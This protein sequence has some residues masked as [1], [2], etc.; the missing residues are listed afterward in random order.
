[1]K[2]IGLIGGMSWESTVTYYE[3]LNKEVAG[4]LG[5]FHSA[6]ILMYNV[7]FAELEENMS[8]GYWAGNAVILADA[9]TRLEK[10]GADFIVIATNTMHKLVDEIQKQINIPILHI[11][12]AAADAVKCD[13]IRKVGLLGTKFTMT[14][15]FIKS[16]L[17]DAGLEVVI[18]DDKDIELVNDVIFNELCL[19]KVLDSSRKEYQRIIDD[20]KAKGA[21]GVILGCT[22][23]GMLIGDK[24]SCLPTYDTTIIHAKAAVKMA[25]A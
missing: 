24:D 5:G 19:G 13:N 18:P 1:M 25:L 23:I 12:D 14:Q 22:E 11:S 6:K 20:M 4:A 15:D 21:E 16:R 9:A 8:N 2:T 17:S 10:A 7:D 3:I